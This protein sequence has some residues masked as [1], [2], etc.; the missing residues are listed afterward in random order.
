M[1]AYQV[2]LLCLVQC[3]QCLHG[4]SSRAGSSRCSAVCWGAAPGQFLPGDL[5]SCSLLLDFLSLC[6]FPFFFFFFFIFYFWLDKM[7]YSRLNQGCSTTHS[8][9]YFILR[10]V[11]AQSDLEAEILLLWPPDSLGLQ[12]CSWPHCTSLDLSLFSYYFIIF[13]RL[14]N[15]FIFCTELCYRPWR[16]NQ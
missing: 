3:C 15:R 1:W 8:A 5:P 11:F 6:A 13:L 9:F 12:A 2:G 7:W 14:A 16:I 10:Q 4:L